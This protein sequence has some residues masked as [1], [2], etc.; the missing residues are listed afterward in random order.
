MNKIP[1]GV[2]SEQHGFKATPWV[3]GW[4]CSLLLGI[5]LV[6]VYSKRSKRGPGETDFTETYTGVLKPSHRSQAES[7]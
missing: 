2:A 4:L 7:E 3:S 6:F 5:T 1:G